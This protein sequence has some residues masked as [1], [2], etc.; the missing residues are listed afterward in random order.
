M[1]NFIVIL[2]SL[3]GGWLVLWPARRYLGS[4]EWALLGLPVGL[5]GWVTVALINVILHRPYSVALLISGWVIFVFLGY[6]C[7]RVASRGT[8]A[9]TEPSYF[10]M[11]E[12]AV[13]VFATAT[14]I[15]STMWFTKAGFTSFSQDSYDHYE[16]FGSYLSITGA[17]SEQMIS[18]RMILLPAVH[19]AGR[20]LGGTWHYLLYSM[21]ALVCLALILSTTYRFTRHR[22]GGYLSLPIGLSIIVLLLLDNEIRMFACYVHGTV[23]TALYLTVAVVSVV[24]AYLY[25]DASCNPIE[26]ANR[27]ARRRVW[28]VVAGFAA[29]G[30]VLARPDG[31]AYGVIPIALVLANDVNTRHRSALLW[32]FAPLILI[33][34]S[35]VLLFIARNGV[36]QSS[37]LDGKTALAFIMLQVVAA[38]VCLV[39]SRCAIRIRTRSA[40]A[41]I[42]SVVF[43]SVFT[44][45]ILKQ[46]DATHA[47]SVMLG[48]LLRE[49][50]WRLLWI[51][52][53]SALSICF[54]TA[55]IFAYK[56]L[57]SVLASIG[58]FF[59]IAIL[60]H[61]ATHPG[62]L[63]WGDSFN[64]LSFHIIPLSF[65]FVVG[66]ATAMATQ[67]VR[68]FDDWIGKKKH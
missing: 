2:T 54:V 49:G 22:A 5:F 12:K 16:P 45:M 1:S 58:L 26:P 30:I 42:F 27:S 13:A 10:G 44:L 6:L 3:L 7:F 41:I 32:F 46:E 37:K 23:V 56:W 59:S 15:A 33:S 65:L 21:S 35:F 14:M 25:P 24:M 17:I 50:E 57:E 36:W 18:E 68:A 38:G 61:G 63:G 40:F 9:I 43:L 47:V 34:A 31:F 60:T 19:A 39:L 4:F 29:G 55:P 52:T 67:V 8:D 64:R 51:Y 66:C 62:R 20:F 11:S 28:L 48:N 53:F